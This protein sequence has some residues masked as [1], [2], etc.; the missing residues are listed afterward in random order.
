[1]KITKKEKRLL[2]TTEVE[3][4]VDVGHFIYQQHK[5]LQRKLKRAGVRSND[6][7]GGTAIWPKTA[8]QVRRVRRICR[9]FGAT[10]N[11]SC[12]YRQGFYR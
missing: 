7:V 6:T 4:S 10:L 1:M 12:T 2:K 11:K 9:N 5:A 8:W 3:Y